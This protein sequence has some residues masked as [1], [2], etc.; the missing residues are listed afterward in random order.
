MLSA[1]ISIK[2][3]IGNH[4]FFFFYFLVTH[5]RTCKDYSPPLISICIY[6]NRKLRVGQ[7]LYITYRYKCLSKI[8]N[9]MHCFCSVAIKSQIP[10]QNQM[11]ASEMFHLFVLIL[12]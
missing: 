5:Y 2:W 7:Y 6:I 11:S 1:D 10:E 3:H 4:H 12:T 8:P 9:H